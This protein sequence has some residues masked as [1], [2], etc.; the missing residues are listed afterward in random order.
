MTTE[1]LRAAHRATPFRPFKIRMADGRAFP[2][3]HPDFLSI[4]PAG[5]TVVIYQPDG[6]A[7]IVDLLL[8]TE[9]E[10]SPPGEPAT[11]GDQG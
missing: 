2:V 7:S 5:R 3:P 6:A 10:W 8:M 11:A 1:Q 9:L 4:S